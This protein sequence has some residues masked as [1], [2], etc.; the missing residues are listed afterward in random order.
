MAPLVGFKMIV[1]ERGGTKLSSLLSNKN[2][3]SGMECGRKE[4]AVCRQTGDK[5]EDCVRRNILYESECSKCGEDVDVTGAS[6]ERQGKEA[7]LYVGETAR[8]LFE[9]SSKHC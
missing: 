9:R 4:C 6:L 2:L 8:S 1:T 7:S 3:C 5:K